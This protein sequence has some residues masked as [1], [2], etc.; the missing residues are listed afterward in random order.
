MRN[1]GKGTVKTQGAPEP[2]KGKSRSS[3]GRGQTG[4]RSHTEQN[5]RQRGRRACI[6]DPTNAGEE[7][8]RQMDGESDGELYRWQRRE[9]CRA[10]K[11]VAV[12][13][14]VGRSARWKRTGERVRC[15]Q[16]AA[17]WKSRGRMAG[18]RGRGGGDE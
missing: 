10:K 5:S 14:L 12:D 11:T 18:E 9:P 13:G 6:G 2:G 7:V 1:L 16:T 15:G 4:N 17:F 8:R 3:E